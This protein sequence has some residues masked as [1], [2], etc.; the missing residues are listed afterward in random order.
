[1]QHIQTVT[2]GSGGAASITFSAIPDTF[3]DLVIV[4]SVRSNRAAVGDDVRIDL[5]TTSVGFTSRAL[6][7]TGSA[8]SSFSSDNRA[9]IVSAASST[10]NTFGSV[11]LY[12]PNYRS[13][14]AKSIST[15]SVGENNATAADQGIFAT[16]WNPAVHAVITEAKLYPRLG[17]G[18]LEH[19]SASLYGITAGSDG[20]TAVS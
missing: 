5:N 19:S 6:V 18:W 15:D 11:S 17:S 20:I 8:A 16:L 9:G 12:I 10:G 1:M 13:L 4:A 7:G 14:V 3:T 2:V